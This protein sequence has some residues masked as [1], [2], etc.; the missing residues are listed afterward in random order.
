MANDEALA[1]RAH[2]VA[3]AAHGAIAWFD[4]Q[5]ELLRDDR[6]GLTR[7]FR[8]HHRRAQRLAAAAARPMCAAVFGP[9]QAGKSYLIGALARKGADPLRVKLGAET[10]DFLAEINPQG[11]KESTGL[12]TRFSIRPQPSQV[13]RPVAVRLLSATDVVKVI[14]NAF[15][16]DFNRDKIEPLKPEA[17]AELLAGL[18]IRA[19]PQPQPGMTEDDVYD[20]AEYMRQYFAGHPVVRALAQ[21]GFWT[22]AATLAPRLTVPDRGKLFGALW[23]AMPALTATATSLMQALDTLGYADSAFLP[24]AALVPRA[25]SV[26]DVAAL[27]GLDGAAGGAAM[28]PLEMATPAGRVA[29]VPRA[30]ATAL[31]AELQLEL[32]D[33]PWDFFNST[34]LL[35]F[36]GA[37]SRENFTDTEKF[38]GEGGR[39][40]DLFLRG[41]VAYLFQRY[42]ADQELTAML[43]CVAEGNQEVRTLPAMIADWVSR[44]HGDTPAKRAAQQ[45]SLFLVLTKFD[46]EFADKP[47][48]EGEADIT[49]WSIRMHTAIKGFLGQE[50]GWPE[51]WQ[52]G[53][54]F[55]NVFWLRNPSFKNEA[56]FDY[57]G[58]REL[59]LRDVQKDRFRTL[60]A[61][62]MAN[63]DVQRHFA[64][65]AQS[66]DAA[67][68]VND[69]GIGFLAEKLAPVCRPELKAA[70]VAAQLADL[71]A[72]MAARLSPYHRS[73][74]IEQELAKRR[75]EARAA[76]L[77]LLECA[78]RQRFG[79]LLREWCVG[80]DRFADLFYR[81]QFQAAP[82]APAPVRSI[83]TRIDTNALASDFLLGL[84]DDTPAP[85]P[86]TDTAVE[87]APRDQAGSF[88]AAALAEWKDRLEEF[89][90]TPEAQAHFLLDRDTANTVTQQLAI[91][92]RRLQ[93][94]HGLAER[95]RGSLYREH[96]GESVLRLGVVAAEHFG[97][98]VA[99]LGFDA[100]PEAN[101]PKAGREQRP[102]FR[103]FAADED[104]PRLSATPE[105][106]DAA[107]TLDWVTAFVRLTEDNVR[108]DSGSAVD[109]AANAA[110]GKLLATLAPSKA[111]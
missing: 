45:T 14:A 15:F 85:P 54:P 67:M 61:G 46:T 47:G 100:V 91:G 28:P 69:G 56:L 38:A 13:G 70:Q 33:R 34:D 65:P 3:E 50:F 23:N 53:K 7:E 68:A 90:D 57:D 4:S 52:P 109:I 101:R 41:K 48:M 43:L 76:G 25:T 8:R 6:A 51:E 111:A 110:L 36:P 18:K 29:T 88:A 71:A 26:I 20:V 31:I 81:L 93:L 66:W 78:G 86:P 11:G 12:V 94:A 97:A 59:G 24:M 17:V 102:V 30:I 19:A 73:G 84:G 103:A 77:K 35:D 98:Y 89:A 63:A 5:A 55:T 2:A 40:S 106:F 39:I 72:T 44:T 92:A 42:V 75:S 83:G 104:I 107:Y 79:P 108:G 80:P 95:I 1:A 60:R 64:D 21:Q 49:R 74:D 96:L 99:A 10:V 87:E 82:D 16:E 22:D 105:P 62:F 37:R 32:T 27:A 9:S 58:R